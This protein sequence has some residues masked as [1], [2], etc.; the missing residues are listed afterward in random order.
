VE[1]VTDNIT[2]YIN[3]TKDDVL[4]KDIYN[5]IHHGDHNSFMPSLLPMSSLGTYSHLTTLDA[6]AIRCFDTVGESKT[7]P[8]CSISFRLF[9]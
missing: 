9:N 8:Q 7:F 1:Y 2:Q 3:Y 6:A 4:G 5:I